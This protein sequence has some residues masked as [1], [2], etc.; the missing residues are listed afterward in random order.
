MIPMGGQMGT[1]LCRSLASVDL[2]AGQEWA[3][4]VHWLAGRLAECIG[5]ALTVWWLDS[6]AARDSVA[7]FAM[8]FM[9][10]VSCVLGQ[11][12]LFIFALFITAIT[13][14]IFQALMSNQTLYLQHAVTPQNILLKDI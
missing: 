10:V 9:L 11:S 5:W 13:A 4:A 2:A 14:R 1:A 12:L 6:A 3:A 7:G 8:C